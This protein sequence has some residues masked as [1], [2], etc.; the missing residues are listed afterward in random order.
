MI[1]PPPQSIAR[2]QQ[3]LKAH[4]ILTGVVLLVTGLVTL[5]T[6]GSGLD[7]LLAFYIGSAVSG[8]TVAHRNNFYGCAGGFESAE[9]SISRTGGAIL[10]S[11]RK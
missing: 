7:T 3:A 4:T 10:L 11:P 5:N 6:S 9:R 8:L 2:L 1:T